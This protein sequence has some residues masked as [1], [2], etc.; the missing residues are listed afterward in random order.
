MAQVASYVLTFEGTT[1]ANPKAPEGDIWID[2]HMDVDAAE[3]D[4]VQIGIEVDTLEFKTTI[5]E[6]G[7]TIE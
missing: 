2:P 4:S 5:D 7:N 1:A 3:V 6:G